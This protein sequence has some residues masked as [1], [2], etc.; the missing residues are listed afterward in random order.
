MKKE[1]LLKDKSKVVLTVSD[2]FSGE[3]IIVSKG[4][5]ENQ[6]LIKSL[7][8]SIW[9]DM[10]FQGFS[11]DNNLNRVE[12]EFDIND[13]IYF[14]L[15]RLLDKD[16]KIVIDDDYTSE[17]MKKYMV[18]Q[19]EEKIIR[20]VFINSLKKPDII[21]TFRVFIKNIG[22]DPRS[23]IDDFN[24][25][26]RLIDFLRDCK[27]ILTEEYHQVTLDEYTEVLRQKEIENKQ[28]KIK[29]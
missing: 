24:T 10:S 20:I 12:F 17:L 6:R 13:P 28:I 22:P 14:C 26:I 19:R 29:V 23:K 3:S 9:D 7:N 15:N 8:L 4:Y 2:S 27:S 1:F 5:F 11:Y 25:K 18:I 16:K 21:E